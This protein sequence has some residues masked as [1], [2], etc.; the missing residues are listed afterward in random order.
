MEQTN[1]VNSLSASS[2]IG[3]FVYGY[4]GKPLGHVEDIM[5]NIATG[6]VHYFILAYKN[7][8]KTQHYAIPWNETR[9]DLKKRCFVIPTTQEKLESV[10][11]LVDTWPDAYSEMWEKELMKFYESIMISNL[12]TS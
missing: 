9:I 2:L 1:I 10:P 7:N 5:L 4:E 8:D 12:V 3:D 11:G 6:D